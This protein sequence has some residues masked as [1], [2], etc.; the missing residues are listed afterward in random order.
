MQL[1]NFQSTTRKKCERAGLFLQIIALKSGL[2]KEVKVSDGGLD[3]S[4][5]IG[6]DDSIQFSSVLFIQRQI[7]TNVISRHFDDTVQFKPIRVQ[8][9]IIIIQSNPI[10]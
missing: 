10:N 8:F 5:H 7:T 4:K 2:W 1:A 9:I 3:M 6:C